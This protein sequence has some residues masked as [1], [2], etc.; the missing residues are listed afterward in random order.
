MEIKELQIFSNRLNEQE[1]LYRNVLGFRCVRSSDSLLEIDA[2]RTRLI[3]MKSASKFFYHFAFL[4]PTGAL[5]SAI[6]YLESKSRKLLTLRGKKIVHFDSGRAVYFY[7]EDGNIVEFI[8]RPT[9]N[10]ALKTDFDIADIIK[11]N[12]IGLP[13]SDP[14]KMTSKLVS[15]FGI[16]PI[17]NAP[18]LDK[19]C[20]VGDHNGAIIA[21]KQGRNW[22]PTEKAGIVNDFSI[23]YTDSGRD[24]SL[25]FANN[26]VSNMAK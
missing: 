17:E 4:I 18:Y 19:F 5:E 6:I 13:V 11:I 14:K 8:E 23:N 22:L 25:T 21:T 16:V 24:Y 12:E 20:W 10:Y 9:L 1:D 7:D 26:E 2:G 15:E 3:L